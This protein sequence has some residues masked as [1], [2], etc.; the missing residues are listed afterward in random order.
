VRLVSLEI[1]GFKSFPEKTIINFNDNITG[2]VGPNGC[3]K[4]NIVDAIRW[5]LG[6]QKTSVL[7]SE[8]MENVI[9]NGTK[10]RK[11][12]ALAEV[13][14]TLDNNRNL[15]P[16]DYHTVTI[17]R[18]YFRSGDSEYRLN[19]VAC[20]LK[21]ITNL[22]LDTG[23]SSDSYAIIELPMIN[24]ILNDKDGSRRK[25]FE[26]A[27]GI[28]KYKARKKETMN[29]LEATELDINRVE[30]LLFEIQNNLKTLESQAKKA[31]RYYKLKEEYMQL[32]IQLSLFSIH[33]IKQSFETL[34]KQH[35]EEEQ[36]KIEVDTDIIT[37][38]A[39]I[40]KEKT[41]N[42]EKEKALNQQQKLLNEVTTGIQKQENEK[43][44]LVENLKYIADKKQNLLLQIEQASSQ[45]TT[46]QTDVQNLE[47]QKSS[48]AE[49]LIKHEKTTNNLKTELEQIRLKHGEHR[50]K[51]QEQQ[52]H[53]SVNEKKI[54][55]TDRSLSVLNMQSETLNNELTRLTTEYQQRQQLLENLKTDFTKLT[56]EEENQKTLIKQV[57]DENDLLQMQ[58]GEAQEKLDTTRQQLID[59]NRKLDARQNE[60]QLTKSFVD[61]MEGF[62]ESIKFLKQNDSQWSKDA[63]LL[64]DVISCPAEW[65]T[66]VESFLEP[67]LNYYVV[68]DTRE[69]WQALNLL[70]SSQ[71]GRANF[72]VLSDFKNYQKKNNPIPYNSTTALDVV[73]VEGQYTNLANY[74]LDRVFIT[75]QDE[76]P[77]TISE[78]TILLNKL[79]KFIRYPYSI[80]GGQVGSFTGKRLG[81]VK[82]LETLHSDIELL[83]TQSLAATEKIE[84]AQVD[85]QQLRSLSANEQINEVREQYN[86][87]RNKL[88][89]VKTKIENLE[90]ANANYENRN[91]YIQQRRQQINGEL[92]IINQQLAQLQNEKSLHTSSLD[93]SQLQFTETDTLLVAQN[94]K[95][96][97]TNLQFLQLKHLVESTQQELQFKNLQL[98]NIHT[99]I[100]TNNDSISQIANEVFDVES[101]LKV[102]SEHLI[103]SYQTKEEH[104]GVVHA[105]EQIYFESK[106][107]INSA[108]EAIRQMHR[109]KEQSEIILNAIKEK[110]NELKLELTGLRERLS[111]EF[112]TDIDTL[113]DQQPPADKN[114]EELTELVQKMKGRIETYGEVN[115]MAMEAYNEMKQRADFIDKQK[116]DLLNAKDSLIRTINEIEITAKEQFMVA[117]TKV[118]EN[119]IN[120]YHE[121]FNPDDDCDLVLLEPDNLLESNIEIVAKPKGKRPS[122]INQ[123][124]GGE[125]ALTAVSLLFA[126]YLLKPAPFCILDEVDAPLD[127]ANIQKF[128]DMIRK[129]STDSQFI[130]VTHNKQTM[131]TVDVI[132]G[133]TMA[134]EGVS[135][136]VPVDFRS[137]NVESP[138]QTASA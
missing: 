110:I 63:P 2:V 47:I 6:E 105:T 100:N 35:G 66:A 106:N 129:F 20:R 57:T 59:I 49:E 58:I 44:L 12:S 132:Y 81:R 96:N 45:V 134:E 102:I 56:A 125:K 97:A 107:K 43:N 3:G 55:E 13:T 90:S 24:D 17:S 121:L 76:M 69:A 133:V 11:S 103:S 80:S 34:E 18:H 21:D 67:Y 120:V 32:S 51:L 31:E 65:R 1:K 62:P 117:F 114:P 54:A 27:A 87:I 113:M 8:K 26:Q 119:F 79:G 46:L 131:A 29:K 118:K 127:D 126:L 53:F 40:Q 124:S 73:D 7:R 9:F 98:Q 94:E 135:K 38:E 116:A 64:S 92:E 83:T 108:E 30:D 50:N 16:T 137:L 15:L 84:R 88:I 68:K 4:S 89:E 122:T 23:I 115:P 91:Q 25:L 48:R 75:E 60:F 19:N 5:V 104:E 61:N 112:K 36:K 123:L 42:L 138:A 82:N 71:K 86:L 74:L 111:I 77:S 109:H 99:Q 72:F 78:Q 136:V 70:G 52:G 93:A 130:V 10:S 39:E 28:S 22:F 37:R 85:L 41:D 14:L 33:K 95:F 101:K 128:N